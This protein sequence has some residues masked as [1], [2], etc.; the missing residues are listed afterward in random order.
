MLVITYIYRDTE[1][2]KRMAESVKKQGYELAVIRTSDNPKEI[3]RQLYECYK[4][5][6]TV[7][8]FIIY[9]DSADTYF[10]RKVNIPIDHL[11]YST[12]A[13]CFPHPEWA[14]RFT[15]L[16]RWRYLNNG[17]IAGPS[18]LFVEF[19]EKYNLHEVRNNAQAE[20]QEAYFAGVKDGFPVK[21]DWMCEKFQ[22]VAFEREGEFKM[23]NGLL[24]NMI[25]T[26][27]PAVLH[28]NG[29]TPLEKFIV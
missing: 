26:T 24:R 12:E 27:T 7:Y 18:K 3:M 2:T 15:G 29:I 14:D 28:G 10:Q 8:D 1:G 17:L 19:F 16:S 11:L 23:Y 13:Q 9:A 20:A 21:L 4:R 5:A 22:S 25:T 6:S